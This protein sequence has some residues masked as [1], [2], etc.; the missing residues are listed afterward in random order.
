MTTLVLAWIGTAVEVV[1]GVLLSG[2]SDS[3]ATAR[4][5]VMAPRRRME[6]GN[7]MAAA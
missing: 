4:Q 1:G 6:D 7:A 5:A 3:A 2:E